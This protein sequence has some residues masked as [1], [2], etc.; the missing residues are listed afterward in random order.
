M[1]TLDDFKQYIQSVVYLARLNIGFP[2][3]RDGRLKVDADSVVRLAYK[4]AQERTMFGGR[5]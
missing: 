3:D 4:K 2:D 1:K 5:K